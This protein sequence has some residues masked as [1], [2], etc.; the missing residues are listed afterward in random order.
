MQS[1]KTGNIKASS[2]SKHDQMN[3]PPVDEKF[4]KLFL[5]TYVIQQAEF[6]KTKDIDDYN[7]DSRPLSKVENVSLADED[8]TNRLLD[9]EESPKSCSDVIAKNSNSNNNRKIINEP[10]LNEIKELD[11]F[12]PMKEDY[13]CVTNMYGINTDN[14]IARKFG[15]GKFF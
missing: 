13:E 14:F 12:N 15:Y 7:V 8:K 4:R 2:T 11:D 1:L 5:S 3:L 9:N 6:D 10:K